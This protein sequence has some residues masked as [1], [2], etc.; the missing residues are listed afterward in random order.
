MRNE[1]A[2]SKRVSGGSA[3][4][5]LIEKRPLVVVVVEGVVFGLNGGT[6]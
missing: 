5:R 1:F 6:V 2:S 3:V 4:E